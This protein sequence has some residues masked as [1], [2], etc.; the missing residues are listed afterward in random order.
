MNKLHK[1]SCQ[2][3]NANGPWFWRTAAQSTGTNHPARSYL[4]IPPFMGMPMQNQ[5]I[6]ATANHGIQ[7]LQIVPVTNPHPQSIKRNFVSRSNVMG[8]SGLSHRPDQ[9][10]LVPVEVAIHKSDLP[11]P[12]M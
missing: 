10:I 3:K 4:F 8:A 6:R 1:L 2:V 11:S 9:R 7:H 5:I 12:E